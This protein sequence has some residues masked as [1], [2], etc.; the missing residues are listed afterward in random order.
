VAI[1][2]T[3]ISSDLSFLLILSYGSCNSLF[4]N[5][6]TSA[7]KPSRNVW[8]CNYIYLSMALQPFVWP[9][10]LFSFL[11][12]HGV[13]RTPWAEDQPAARPLPTHRVQR[14]HI[15]NAQTSMPQVGFESTI[16]V[17]CAGE[18]SSCLR[19]HGH[20][21]R[22]CN[23]IEVQNRFNGSNFKCKFFWCMLLLILNWVSLLS[24]NI[25]RI[26]D[27]YFCRMKWDKLVVL[28]HP[29]AY[30]CLS[31]RNEF[32]NVLRISYQ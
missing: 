14:K 6:Y 1:E 7:N 2:C 22:H 19:P 3:D 26:N 31:Q 27:S 20:C 16:S 5:P 12:P 17:F 29:C 13:G 23:F 9:W 21:D 28:L 18:D 30:Q 11:I 10:P 32:W 24:S 8:N 25:N 15:I 4:H